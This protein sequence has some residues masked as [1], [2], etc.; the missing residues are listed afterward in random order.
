MKESLVGNNKFE[1]DRCRTKTD[2]DTWLS[3]EQTNKILLVHLKRF[4]SDGITTRKKND[5]IEMPHKFVLTDDQYELFA[6]VVHLSQSDQEGHYIAYSKYDGIWSEY[7]DDDVTTSVNI[8]KVK[9]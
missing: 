4:A 9:D 6:L 7:N 5:S 1:C 3:L 8:D 2:A